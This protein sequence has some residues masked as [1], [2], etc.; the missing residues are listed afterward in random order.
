MCPSYLPS[1]LKHLLPE[2]FTDEESSITL[3][4]SSFLGQSTWSSWS[5]KGVK[6]QP[7]YLISGQLYRAI[8]SGASIETI[9]IQL[10]LLPDSI[11]FPCNLILKHSP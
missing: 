9:N 7:L 8:P 10:F 2:L 4:T 5:V 1:R 3:N 6:A 11:A